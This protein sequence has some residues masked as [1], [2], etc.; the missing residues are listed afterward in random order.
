M[1]DTN[2]RDVKDITSSFKDGDEVIVE[3]TGRGE[4]HRIKGMAK[5]IRKYDNFMLLEGINNKRFK[6]CI[7]YTDIISGDCII[8]L[9]KIRC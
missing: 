4:A 9:A 3:L 2:I 5:I 8:R 7:L 6:E 1:M